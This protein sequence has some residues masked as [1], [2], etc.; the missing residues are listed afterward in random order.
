VEAGGDKLRVLMVAGT[1]AQ[2]GAEKQLVHMAEALRRSDV[3]VRVLTL[4]RAEFFEERLLSCG[5]PV[6]AF[7]AAGSPA[8]RLVTLVQEARHFRPQ[9]VHAGHFFTNLYVAAVGRA[10]GAVALGA[11]RSDLA[12][13]LASVGGWGTIS[14]RCA[15]SL[16]ANSG[17]AIRAAV[18]RGVPASRLHLLS[19]VVDLP[20]DRTRAAVARQLEDPVRG[21]TVAVVARLVQAKRLDR[22]LH[23]LV[24]AR[25][26][27]PRVHGVIAG[28][29]PERAAL[30]ALARSLGLVPD[31]V[32]FVGRIPDVGLLLAEAG[33]LALTSEHEGVPNVILEA[34]AMGLP[35]V[36]TPAGDAGEIVLDGVTGYVTRMDQTDAMATALVA[37]AR[38]PALRRH[39]GEAGRRR[40]TE[41][42]SAHGLADRLLTIYH[43]AAVRQH[44]R[45]TLGRRL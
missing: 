12:Y 25:A 34:M 36:T 24:A 14:L 28:E 32:A 1:L 20:P 45:I 5:I 22:F 17:R 19:N 30:E 7:G 21:A 26:L 41:H 40:V 16:I 10:C 2:G 35:V 42:F 44:R 3:E 23:A 15:P 33:M 11:I 8:R 31:G 43:T 37:L 29:G 13:D 18:A 39:M 4:R 9:V 38:S 6:V 27:E